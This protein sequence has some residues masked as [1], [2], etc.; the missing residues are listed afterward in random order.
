MESLEKTWL[1]DLTQHSQ[2]NVVIALCGNKCDLVQREEV[3]F[4][5]GQGFASKNNIKIFK[6][7]SA[8]EDLGINELFEK[9]AKKIHEQEIIIR[10]KEAIQLNDKK[11]NKKKEGCKC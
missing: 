6:Q 2:P 3:N 5:M 9:I 8:K 10:E 11:K 1:S 4:Q 7:T